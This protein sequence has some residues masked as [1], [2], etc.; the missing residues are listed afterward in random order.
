MAKTA[1]KRKRI[2][3]LLIDNGLITEDQL[4]D[5]LDVQRTSNEQIGRIMVN[6]G[7]V[8]ELDVL[9]MLAVQL[10]VP[11]VDLSRVKIVPVIAKSL[12]PHVAQ[13]HKVIPISKDKRKIVLAMV[14]PLNVFAIDEVKLTTGLEVVPVLAQEEQLLLAV[15]ANYGVD[16]STQRAIESLQKLGIDPD[17]VER[18]DDD[19][20]DDITVSNVKELSEDS[21][22]VKLVNAII[23]QAIDSRASDIHIEPMREELRV[24][25]RVDG[26]LVV[27]MK[28]PKKIQAALLSRVKV[29]ADLNIAEKRVPQDGRIN[30]LVGGKEFDFRVST[31]P[32]QHG[33]KI[34]LR[35]L[36]KSSVLIGLNRLG[37]ST[38][39]QKEFESLIHSPV[40]MLLV[41]GPTGS[42]K[43][44]TLYS[45]LNQLNSVSRHIITVEDP[46]EYMLEGINQV[47]V[48]PKANV[49]FANTLRSFL[50]ND[51]DMIMV[52]EI[53]DKET[54]EIAIQAA[55]TGHLV[56]STLHTNDAPSASTR[57]IDMGIEPFL[58]SSSMIG[59]LAQRLTRVLCPECKV[60]Y[61]PTESELNKLGIPVEEG[62]NLTFYK[63]GGC[64]F[65]HD[66]GYRG[67][68]GIYELMTINDQFKDMIVRKVSSVK[69]RELAIKTGMQTL[70]QDAI[71]KIIQG[72]TSLEEAMRV[73]YVS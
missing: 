7:F 38:E 67:R 62:K 64:E 47:Q 5:A 27:A 49:N 10:G 9:K 12:Q 31:Y 26:V 2:G 59:A 24:R 14:N 28:P 32:T 45:A 52:G 29:L 41:T 48:N 40:G 20:D 39:V 70:Q 25:Y 58:V 33:E 71:K 66:I 46:V 6:L 36:D 17:S 15:H 37:F 13:R 16:E 44:T 42:G 8:T 34:V 3:E 30:L 21:P 22:I 19:A 18:L 57:L 51:P 60:P 73:V 50:R 11:F 56:L 63:P 65:C 4:Q 35:I 72:I 53:R 1:T 69:L 55:L 23:V 61:K 54:A 68:I 43:S